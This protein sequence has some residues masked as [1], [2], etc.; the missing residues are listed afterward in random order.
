MTDNQ[1]VFANWQR[2]L[3]RIVL[4]VAGVVI[5]VL[6]IPALISAIALMIKIS[7][8]ANSLMGGMM[9][10]TGMQDAG[11]IA[12]IQPVVQIIVGVFLAELSD[13][14]AS[15]M[16]SDHCDGA[17]KC[18][19]DKTGSNMDASNGDSPYPTL[20]KRIQNKSEESEQQ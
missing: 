1:D 8:D 3:V 5:A 2:D 9:R 6:A 15:R 12:L 19:D 14:I 17:Q 18:C 11:W 10:V 7:A 13:L 4:Y 20:Q 16:Y